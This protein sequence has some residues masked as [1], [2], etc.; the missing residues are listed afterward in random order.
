MPRRSSKARSKPRR[1][2]LK[3]QYGA[4]I[5]PIDKRKVETMSPGI[6]VAVAEWRAM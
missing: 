6:L 4:V 3:G 2:K 1:K 5:V